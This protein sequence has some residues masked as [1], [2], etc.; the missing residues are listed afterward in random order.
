MRSRRWG[1]WVGVA[2]LPPAVW[3]CGH[4]AAV[5]PPP[6]VPA[7]AVRPADVR[8]VAH[9]EAGVTKEVP[10]SLDAIFR[11]AEANNPRVGQA[12]EKLAESLL[13]QEMNCRCWLP[14]TY[15]GLT[16]YRHEGGIQNENG[17][18]THS[19]TGAVIPGLNVQSELDL[20][21]STFRALSDERN[22]WQNRA[23][24]TQIN[25]EILL[26]AAT[27]YVDLLTARRGAALAEEL[28]RSERKVLERA[29]KLAKR[30]AAAAA[31]V[32]TAKATVA[33]RQGTAAKL[34]QQANAASLKLVYLLGLPPATVLVPADKV[35]TP[36]ELVDVTPPTEALVG[37][38][39][40]AGPGVRELEGLLNVIQTGLDKSY[41]YHNL[42]PTFGVNVFE[43][44]IGAGPGGSL[45][46]DNRLDVTLSMRWNL[47]EIAKTE[48]NRQRARHRQAQTQYAMSDLR[49]K[50][51]FGVQ[52]GKDAVLHGREQ[53]GLAADQ[54]R[55]S[56]EGYRLSDKRLEDGA[57]GASPSD[58]L[59]AVRGL[60]Q[61]H[62]AHLMAIAAHNKAQI[63]LVLLLGAS[64]P[65]AAAV[66]L[67]PVP[68]PELPLP[69]EKEEKKDDDKDG[70]DRP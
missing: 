26:E 2:C 40:T 33:N 61:A 15:A 41:G 3:G 57:A 27:T 63:R 54:I 58:V 34:R 30:E 50:L 60:E 35:I 43:G 52:E 53:I 44:A 6:E 31:L 36:V 14:N 42:L 64:P 8:P 21:E 32:A 45:A 49:G 46:F 13:V 5:A 37:R 12:R 47:A 10:V 16:Y 66:E 18:L 25:S 51:A 20:R 59:L 22:V 38:A 39:V 65:A 68:P 28:E 9:A 29:E 24:L 1:R 62:F 4:H 69:K 67:K 23:E 19:S 11:L 56:S 17:T 70:A 55:E 48:Y 7:A